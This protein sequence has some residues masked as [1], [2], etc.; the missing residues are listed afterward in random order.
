M[1]LMAGNSPTIPRTTVSH[2][3][4]SWCWLQRE[5]GSKETKWVSACT[6]RCFHWCRLCLKLKGVFTPGTDYLTWRFFVLFLFFGLVLVFGLFFVFTFCDCLYYDFWFFKVIL[7]FPFPNST[8]DAWSC[9]I[10]SLWPHSCCHG[11]LALW[12]HWCIR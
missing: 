3:C 6:K 12:L 2:C 9:L 1:F 8:S 5:Q 7:F 10:L 4:W 11:N